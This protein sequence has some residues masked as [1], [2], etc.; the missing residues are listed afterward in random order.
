MEGPFAVL[1]DHIPHVFET[2]MLPWLCPDD[3]VRVRA[4]S[5]ACKRLVDPSQRLAWLMAHREQLQ[6]T[7]KLRRGTS[8]VACEIAAMEGNVPIFEWLSG[9]GRSVKYEYRRCCRLAAR[10]GQVVMLE[11]F[12]TNGKES[13]KPHTWFAV[14]GPGFDSV[15][16]S[17]AAA[18][19]QLGVLRW[20]RGLDCGWDID[21]CFM[22]AAH[23]G[24]INI[25]LWMR[26]QNDPDCPWDESVCDSAAAGGNLLVLQWLRNH[27]CPWRESC[28]CFNA[29]MSGNEAMLD[30]L[31][32]EG[33]V[34]D[35]WTSAGAAR[36]GR[37]GVLRRLLE[38]GVPFDETACAMAAEGGHLGT[39]K[40][41][42]QQGCPWG[43]ETCDAAAE[44]G[45]LN[46][47]QWAF[48][49]GC[50]LCSDG[51]MEIAVASSRYEVTDWLNETFI[52][53]T[54]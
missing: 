22:K 29:A 9:G 23:G 39:L 19:G 13:R 16:C 24:H 42:R 49:E 6:R 18:A 54:D 53:D 48:E 11:W 37:G 32:A 10:M 44:K 30:W 8:P 46:V 45:H 41:L 14:W 3:L 15:V 52:Y 7:V 34:F 25:L 26:D 5:K 38:S 35:A 12:R 27:G 28:V 2:H 1:L 17:E 43:M 51:L 21:G 33:C 31:Y 40:W 50:P 4:V 47:L 20:A 36:K